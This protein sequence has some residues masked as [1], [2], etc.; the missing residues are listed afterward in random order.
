MLLID[1]P[2]NRNDSMTKSF[3]ILDNQSACGT[4][5][6]P[7]EDIP[8]KRQ[9]EYAGSA[10]VV[11][12]GCAKN[13]VDSEVMVGVLRNSGF[14][15]VPSVNDADVVVV[16][17]CGF[18][19]SAINEGVDCILD[20][21]DLKQEGRLRKLIVAGCMV[22]R[23][24]GD[25]SQ[26][27]PEVDVFL[28]TD[29]ILK[30]GSAAGGIE[31]VIKEGGRPYFLYDDTMPRVRDTGWWKA[32][33]KISEGCNRPCTF[34]IIP[35]IRGTF[36][37]RTVDSIRKEVKQLG[38]EGVKEICLVGQ[39]LTAF[40]M[41]NRTGS[42][43]SLIEALEE[44][45]AVDWIRLLYAYPTGI[46]EELL[47]CLKNGDRLVRYLDLPLQHAS[48]RVLKRMCRPTGRFATLPLVEKIK[49]YDPE[50]HLRTTFIV[51][52]PGETEE[53]IRQLE[54]LVSSGVFGSVGVFTYSR[55][56][57]TPSAKMEDQIAA[58]V[59]EE[60]RQRIML[61]QQDV[62]ERTLEQHIGKEYKVLIEGTHEDTDLLLTGRSYFQ[63]PEVDGQILVND[64]ESQFDKI[65][66]GSFYTVRITEVAG[67]DLTGTI[68]SKSQG[69]K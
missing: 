69:R 59:K 21:S 6:V 26:A 9:G 11:T 20:I 64:V 28:S 41:D 52:F 46:S 40:G 5:A 35:K 44:D 57:G 62:L 55:E 39:D 61:A 56:E 58:E 12:L 7:G 2:I 14:E 36:R 19:E 42:I 50:L 66:E 60:R 51:G 33:V 8:E 15:I 48:E 34:C 24:G 1:G 45:Q 38:S 25:I 16:N 32:Y 30:V 18:L 4:G 27:L 10:A 67:Y 43:L 47:S 49:S 22:S 17:T 65:E 53:D 13:Q 3:S 37:S 29:D 63:A 54:E 68:V 31:P 23:F